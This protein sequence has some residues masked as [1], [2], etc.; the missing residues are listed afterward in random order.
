MRPCG[1]LSCMAQLTCMPLMHAGREY[2]RIMKA[3]AD[4]PVV[5]TIVSRGT[6]PLDSIVISV[7]QLQGGDAFNVTPDRARLGGTLRALR[8]DTMESTIERMTAMAHGVAAA[9][10]C[11]AEVTWGGTRP[12]Y[13]PTVND[14][15]AWRFA[16]GVA[17]GCDPLCSGVWRVHAWHIHPRGSMSLF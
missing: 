5:Q 13:P 8:P 2:L 6:S 16:R 4:R 3:D 10:G 17:E 12:V 14:E 11:T 9:H 1:L 15:D 7:T